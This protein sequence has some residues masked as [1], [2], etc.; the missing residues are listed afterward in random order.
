MC[1]SG[2]HDAGERGR[3]WWPSVA[4]TNDYGTYA[5]L[6][7]AIA[8]LGATPSTLTLTDATGSNNTIKVAPTTNKSASTS[9]GGAILV[10]NSQST[11]AGIVVYSTQSAPSGRL[12]VLRSNNATFNQ[13][14]MHIDYTGTNHAM[15]IS[16][17]GTGT[18][19]LGFSVV[20]TNASDTAVGI[21]GACDSRGTIKIT[22]NKS[23]TDTNASMISLLANGS[24]TA[25]QGIFFDTE[26]GVTTSGKLMNF[27]QN[28]SEKFVVTADGYVQIGGN[29]VLQGRITGWGSPTGT[30]TR[31]TFDTTTVTLPQL[32][33]RVK[34]LIDDLKTHGVI[35]T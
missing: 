29:Q 34:A 16:H 24:G 32:A 6:S 21:T 10:D 25:C 20:S 4:E 7:T 17:A 8:A 11:G 31:T 3:S 1:R 30:A 5:R 13:A 15:T 12:M 23:G 19:S 27:C 28:G 18:A 33:E 14:A 35:G 2:A 22:H 26:S 9:V